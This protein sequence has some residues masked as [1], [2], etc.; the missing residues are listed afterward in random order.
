MMGILWAGTDD[1]TI[2][3]TANGGATWSN[4]TPAA[5]KPWTRIFNIEAG[6][7]DDR[8]AYA[9]ANTLRIDDLSPHFWRTHDGGKSWTEINTGIAPG[10]VSN[11]IREDPRVKGL[12]YAATD[13]QVWVSFDD[14]DHWQSLK[15]DMPAISVRDLQV[16]DDSS[17]LCSDLIAGTHGRGFWIL[18]DVTPLRQRAAVESAHDLY[19]LKP[20]IAV[21]MRSGTNDPTPW[22]PELPA[23]E[24]PPVGG[25]IDYYVGSAVHDTLKLEIVNAAGRVVRTYSSADPVLNPDPARDPEAYTHVCQ[26]NPKAPDCNLPL[27]WPAPTAALPTSPGMHRV[28]WDLRFDPVVN[29]REDLAEDESGNGAVPHRTFPAMDAPWAPPGAYTVRLSAGGKRYEQPLTLKL[30]PRVTTPAAGLAQLS[31]LSTEMYDNARA[32]RAAYA[33]ARALRDQLQHGNGANATALAEKVDALAPAIADSDARRD[34]RAPKPEGPPTLKSVGDD[35]MAAA[36]SMQG[37]D[38]TPTANQIAACRR[39]SAAYR[40]VM[41]QWSA[42][43]KQARAA[44]GEN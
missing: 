31:S 21:R 26:Q 17:C 34:P 33:R 19:L 15:L 24:N 7:F 36:M 23:G 5:I 27:Y 13:A 4:V 10:A 2:Q 39:A 42:V 9:A 37:A 28:N 6:H 1:G 32:A 18:D 22:P 41:A 30:D 40:T 20:A 14:G 11:S 12:L 8:T 16:K 3:T 38:I 25:T 44:A 43:E 29:Q 35:L